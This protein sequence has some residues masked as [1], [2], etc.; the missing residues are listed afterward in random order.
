M[1]RGKIASRVDQVSWCLLYLDDLDADFARFYRR[2]W[3]EHDGPRFFARAVR[4]VAYG[5]VMTNRLDA[6]RAEDAAEVVNE[7]PD[8][9]DMTN[10][11]AYA[12]WVEVG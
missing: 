3:W 9:L 4:L 1:G 11:P 7:V 2:E 10:D 6:L 5:G 8:V 12:G